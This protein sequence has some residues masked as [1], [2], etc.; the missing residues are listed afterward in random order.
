MKKQD[1]TLFPA[2]GDGV[3]DK[4]GNHAT[5][6]RP[7]TRGIHATLDNDPNTHPDDLMYIE[8]DYFGS[9][10]DKLYPGEFRQETFGEYLRRPSGFGKTPW[11]FMIPFWW[12]CLV[13]IVAGF[14][15]DSGNAW[16]FGFGFC[17]PII[18]TLGAYFNYTKRWV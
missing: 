1:K 15:A 4:R 5:V 12:F 9:Y 17:M 3:I 2:A 14:V 11:L 18:V 13:C 16:A 10:K 6:I 7:A 8:V